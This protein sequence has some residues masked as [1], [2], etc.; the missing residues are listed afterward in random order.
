MKD[1]FL[2][3]IADQD[4]NDIILYVANENPQAA[5]KL[6]NDLYETMSMIA[7]HP[8]M[9]HKREDL[10]DKPVRFWAFKNHYL[11]VYKDL[12]PIE[13]VRVLSGYRN[14]SILLN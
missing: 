2:S 11:I 10:T 12:S 9:G 3:A 7:T 4:I 5:S 1:Y 6:L 13:I 8:M 14:L